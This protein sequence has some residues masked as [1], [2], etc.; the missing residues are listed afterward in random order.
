M[1][2]RLRVALLIESWGGY[3]RRVLRGIAAYARAHGPW[4]FFH[5]ERDLGTRLPKNLEEWRPDG[6][7]ARLTGA[8]L[9]RQVRQMGLPMVNLTLAAGTEDIP[10]VTSRPE[11]IVRLAIDHF[12]ERGFQHFAYCGFPGALFSELRA[13]CYQEALAEHDR[14]VHLFASSPRSRKMSLAE[15]EAYAL[16]RAEKLAQWLQGLPKPVALLAC[17]DKRGQQVAAACAELGIDVP[18]QVAVLGIDN[19]DVQCELCNPPLS[20]IDPNVEQ[21]GYEAAA[22]LDRL[23]AGEPPPPTL[24]LVEPS[25]V[26]VRRSTDVLAI[27]NREMAEAVRFVRDHA[28]DPELEIE[29]LV[30]QLDL[31]RKTLDRWFQKCLGRSP[32]EEIARVRLA[33]IQ[34]LLATTTLPP[35]EIALLSGFGH[36]GSMCRM[37]KRMTGQSPGEYRQSR[38]L[39]CPKM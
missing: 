3:G 9:I 30:A 7:I 32:H 21:V 2:D 25:R 22:L 36:V 20:T 39:K 10:G 16:G 17:N 23:I 29:D 31:S 15:S 11:S 35:D 34:D 1:A 28:C 38:I 4:A 19:D 5:E 12:L 26:V 24:I 8:R 27:A 13:K 33:R 6:I 37:M 14:P 18:D